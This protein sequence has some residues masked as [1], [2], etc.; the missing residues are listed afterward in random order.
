MFTVQGGGCHIDPSTCMH[1]AAA[2]HRNGHLF[3]PPLD[4]PRCMQELT[5][6]LCIVN[7]RQRPWWLSTRSKGIILTHTV[8]S[9]A[10]KRRRASGPTQLQFVG[11]PTL[12]A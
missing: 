1:Y 4:G 10:G 11:H 2:L 8:S 3:E 7:V 5:S 12:V 6:R 9:T